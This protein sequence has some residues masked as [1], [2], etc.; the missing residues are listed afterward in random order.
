MWQ[1]YAAFF[2]AM[3]YVL[4]RPSASAFAGAV[5]RGGSIALTL[6]WTLAWRVLWMPWRTRPPPRAGYVL[7]G[8]AA[9]DDRGPPSAL[10]AGADWFSAAQGTAVVVNDASGV[11]WDGDS[12]VRGPHVALRFVG[13]PEQPHAGVASADAT[14]VGKTLSALPWGAARLLWSQL[15]VARSLLVPGMAEGTVTVLQPPRVRVRALRFD[16]PECAAHVV[17]YATLVQDCLVLGAL[18]ERVEEFGVVCIAAQRHGTS[19]VLTGFLGGARA[20]VPIVECVGLEPQLLRRPDW[21]WPLTVHFR[22]QGEGGP[23]TEG[24]RKGWP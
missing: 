11:A 19:A 16:R 18:R 20:S 8:V 7:L 4:L 1:L 17:L 3:V 15:A 2:M 5:P 14:A 12:S 10:A 13:G 6:L 23:R 9:A 21:T 22:P 24:G